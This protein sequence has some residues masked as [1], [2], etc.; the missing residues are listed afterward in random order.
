MAGRNSTSNVNDITAARRRIRGSRTSIPVVTSSMPVSVAIDCRPSVMAS[1]I[2]F[3]VCTGAEKCSEP[4]NIHS[5]ERTRT[6]KRSKPADFSIS[7]GEF[8]GAA[9]GGKR[10]DRMEETAERKVSIGETPANY[11]LQRSK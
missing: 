3:S 5:I 9:T 4:K 10:K 7:A 6:H 8:T 11:S 1:G 2:C